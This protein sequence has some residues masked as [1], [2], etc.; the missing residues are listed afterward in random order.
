VSIASSLK[1]Y[2]PETLRRSLQRVVAGPRAQ[3]VTYEDR[4]NSTFLS[5]GQHFIFVPTDINIWQPQDTYP[6]VLP[7]QCLHHSTVD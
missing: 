4:V 2:V 5:V 3:Q 7:V 1:K 6:V